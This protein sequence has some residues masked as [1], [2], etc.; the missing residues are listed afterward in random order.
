ML[1]QQYKVAAAAGQLC[2]SVQ[3]AERRDPT[4]DQT[5]FKLNPDSFW[6]SYTTPPAADS[7]QSHY[8]SYP[9]ST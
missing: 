2:L 4:R 1:L 8:P 6:A 3:I 7:V 9:D 5:R